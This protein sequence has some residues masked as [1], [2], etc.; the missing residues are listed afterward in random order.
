MEGDS[1][2]AMTE[3]PVSVQLAE[4]GD[5]CLIHSGRTSCAG[6]YIELLSR[7]YAQGVRK[8]V[9]LVPMRCLGQI[10]LGSD[11]ARQLFPMSGFEIVNVAVPDPAV[12]LPAHRV[13]ARS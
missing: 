5:Y 2:A 13:P 3:T 10:A 11:L 12:G 9:A 7:L 1:R 6:G 4:G 8:L